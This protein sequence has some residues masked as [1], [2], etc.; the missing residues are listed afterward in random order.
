MD[1]QTITTFI[2][3][4]EEGIG[5]FALASAVTMRHDLPWPFNKVD[6]FNWCY[7]WFRDAVLTVASMKGPPTTPHAE[8]QQQT[9]ITKA[10]DQKGGTIETE[11]KIISGSSAA[12]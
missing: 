9:E 2:K 5:L 12:P 11:V 7:G 4:H 10:T 8:F 1:W 6:I 3:R